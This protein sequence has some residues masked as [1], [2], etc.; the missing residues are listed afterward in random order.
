MTEMTEVGR[1][2]EVHL[3]KSLLQLGHP[4]QDAWDHLQVAVEVLQG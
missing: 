2:L 4:E 3:S 1:D